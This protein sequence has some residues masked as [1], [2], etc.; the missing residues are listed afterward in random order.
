MVTEGTSRRPAIRVKPRKVTR[1]RV[2]KFL[3]SSCG[4]KVL[5]ES[6]PI[7]TLKPD[8]PSGEK[9]YFTVVAW[10]ENKFNKSIPNDFVETKTIGELITALCD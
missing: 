3:M 2:K 7:I 1:A 4:V 10:A 5:D 9:P 6:L 8:V